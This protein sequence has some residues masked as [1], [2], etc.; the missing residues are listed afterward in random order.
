MATQSRTGWETLPKEENL[1]VF[2]FALH[3]YY[4]CRI[5]LNC[6]EFVLY[7]PYTFTL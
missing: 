1:C 6:N 4:I 2:V 3:L 5:H 7:L